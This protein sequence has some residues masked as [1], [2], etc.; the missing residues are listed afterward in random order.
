MGLD[1]GI[2]EDSGES[3]GG[4]DDEGEFDVVDELPVGPADLIREALTEGLEVNPLDD[5]VAV[6]NGN[7]RL[8]AAVSDFLLRW[9]VVYGGVKALLRMSGFIWMVI[10]S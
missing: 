8:F 4:S 6:F 7:G 1:K 3:C 9:A 2:E 10:N 5:L